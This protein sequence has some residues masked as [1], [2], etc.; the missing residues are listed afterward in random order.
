[1]SRWRAGGVAGGEVMKLLAMAMLE[2]ILGQKQFVGPFLGG[3]QSDFGKLVQRILVAEQRW[4][5]TTGE[6]GKL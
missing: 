3:C 2:Q 4:R 6:F 5:Q 1:M